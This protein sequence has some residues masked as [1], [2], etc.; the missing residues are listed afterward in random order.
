MNRTNAPHQH[1]DKSHALEVLLQFL[2][3]EIGRAHWDAVASHRRL[4]TLSELLQQRAGC[5]SPGQVSL[6]F[7]F[8]LI[9]V[10]Q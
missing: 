9:I 1:Q 2:G 3:N 7:C 4:G 5:P 10:I 8:T 6:I